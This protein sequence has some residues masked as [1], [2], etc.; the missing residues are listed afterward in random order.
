MVILNKLV[1]V[2]EFLGRRLGGQGIFQSG[3]RRRSCVK[4]HR[5]LLDGR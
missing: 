1:V 5:R 4:I 2:V 3:E